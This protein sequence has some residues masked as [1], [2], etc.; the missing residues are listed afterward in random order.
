MTER[1]KIS[2]VDVS[3]RE[4]ERL[5]KVNSI[6]RR[7]AGSHTEDDRVDV[8]SAMTCI[9]V[10]SSFIIIIIFFSSSSSSIRGLGASCCRRQPLAKIVIHH[11]RVAHSPCT[12]RD[13]YCV[14]YDRLTRKLS[15]RKDDRAM[16][17]I[18]G[19]PENFRESLSTP[20]GTLPELFNGL[21]FDQSC[22]SAYKI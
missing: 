2:Y 12:R 6:S 20:T 3:K 15:Y 16:R 9:V 11:K 17:P 8:H 5:C 1:E 10:V 18:Y 13:I 19:C 4:V 22:E 21:L 7:P 14:Q